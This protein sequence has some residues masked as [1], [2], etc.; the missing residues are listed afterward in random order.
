[1]DTQNQTTQY[2]P[3]AV[4]M[5]RALKL[6]ESGNNYNAPKEKAGV[7]LGGAY[8]YQAPTWKAYAGD[9]LGDS[10]A[11]FTP[12][13]QDK[14][15]YGMVKKWKD[16]GMQPEEIAHMWNPGDSAYP[17][18]VVEKL[19]SIAKGKNPSTNQ[20]SQTD[21]NTS[22]NLTK[23]T[24][25][26]S[27][28]TQQPDD[29]KAPSNP[30]IDNIPG[31]KLAQGLGYA[32]SNFAGNQDEFIKA[33]NKN[34]E[35]ANKTINDIKQRKTQ[36]K[37]TTRLESALKDLQNNIQKESAQVGDIG[38]GG[39]KNSDVIKSS[40]S[41]AAL[42]ALAYGGSLLS[43]TSA[44]P[45]GVLGTQAEANVINFIAKP[46]IASILEDSGVSLNKFKALSNID[47]ENL[48]TE[49]QS[50]LK[51]VQDKKWISQL[52]TK[53]S[54]LADIESGLAPS[55]TKQAITTG[56]KYVGGLLKNGVKI[57]AGGA[58]AGTGFNEASNLVKGL[59]K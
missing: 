2:D 26:G 32:L 53:V 17:K 54:P 22:N 33:I 41:L 1:M 14:V 56:G 44:L 27:D 10:N 29:L 57:A 34:Q 49:L 35:I 51:S 58:I 50:S 23:D 37:D 4:A 40:A 6:Q 24:I 9:I 20:T 46:Q 38:T 13:N 36:G 16:K 11:Q 45:S 18:Q 12:E 15:T 52:L 59:F 5:V 28:E 3:Q 42:P 30:L 43:G 7:S 8:Q 47:K 25:V 55:A 31:V 39:I 48:L 21:K 19:K